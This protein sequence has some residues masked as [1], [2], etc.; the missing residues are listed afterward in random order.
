MFLWVVA[1]A[2]DGFVKV[3]DGLHDLVSWFYVGAGDALVL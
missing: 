1:D 3:G 2:F